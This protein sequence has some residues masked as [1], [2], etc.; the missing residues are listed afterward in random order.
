MPLDLDRMNDGRLATSD[1]GPRRRATS[2]F[3]LCV[4]TLLAAVGF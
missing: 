3:A 1:G 4:S 2:A